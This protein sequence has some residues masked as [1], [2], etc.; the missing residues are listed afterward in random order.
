MIIPV[1]TN[2]ETREDWLH[3]ARTKPACCFVAKPECLIDFQTRF[4]K[5]TLLSMSSSQHD[6]ITY[7]LGS[8]AS[9]EPAWQLIKGC[10]WHLKAV[11]EGLEKLNFSANV[12]DNTL[13]KR[14]SDLSVRKFFSRQK[15]ILPPSSLGLIQPLTALPE[16]WDCMKMQQLISCQ[17]FCEPKYELA[18][19]SKEPVDMNEVLVLIQDS[20]YNCSFKSHKQRLYMLYKN[21]PFISL[22]PQLIKKPT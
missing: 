19:Y 18:S 6:A 4:L 2:L 10:Q 1:L 13:L 21:E 20:A 3:L 12:R 17:Q 16:T 11:I 15:G 7:S 14:H 22:V 9:I 5:I 8:S